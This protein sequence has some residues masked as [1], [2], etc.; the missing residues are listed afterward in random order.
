MLFSN[1][2]Y[3]RKKFISLAHNFWITGC[4][5]NLFWYGLK[6][7]FDLQKLCL[8]KLDRVR[9]SLKTI[10][11]EIHVYFFRNVGDMPV[12]SDFLNN[13]RI[14]PLF[15]G[16]IST[17]RHNFRAPPVTNHLSLSSFIKIVFSE[18]T[19]DV[20]SIYFK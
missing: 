8:Q 10:S 11:T 4:K 18:I 12:F 1:Y 20:D 15:L 9:K 19:I 7:K 17:G 5:K 6:G 16:V 2:F 13:S 3:G 14:L